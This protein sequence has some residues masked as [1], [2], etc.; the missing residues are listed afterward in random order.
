MVDLKSTMVTPYSVTSVDYSRLINE[1][2]TQPLDTSLL[3]R[4]ERLTHAPVHPL[5]KRGIFFSHRSLDELVTSLESPSP[6]PFYL[7]TG[8]GP[9]SESLHLGHLIPMLMT[10]YLQDAFQVPLVLQIT[11][12]EKFLF[13]DL[14]LEQIATMTRENIKDILAVGFDPAKTF[15][16]SNLEY[17]GTMY[18][19]IVRIQ[20]CLTTNQ[21]KSAFGFTDTDNIGRIAFPAIQ[22]APSFASSFPVVLGGHDRACLIPCAIDQDPFFR[23][24]RDVAPRHHYRKP[25]VLH[26][27][28]F[29]GLQGVQTKMSSSDPTS[30]IFLTDT[31]E[32][33]D[34]KIRLYAFSGGQATLR[35]HREL[36][37]NLEVDV[38]YQYLKIFLPSDDR[39]AEITQAYGSGRMTT[40]EVK[41]ETTRVLTDLVRGHQERRSRITDE[42]VHEVMRVRRLV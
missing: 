29:P 10:K 37:A 23:L 20:K 11:D 40:R 18:P 5:L 19:N 2:G 30:A 13:R 36:G 6:I 21:V 4:I 9:S 22:A 1:F 15:I 35:E 38:P 17:V 27:K 24:T 16:F 41:A 32:Q 26:S 25:A 14:T 34:E 33:I 8:R 39:F 28:F 31:P 3:D 42:Q 12:D 7:Y